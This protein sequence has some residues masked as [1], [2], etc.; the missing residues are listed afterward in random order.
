M[1]AAAQA[2][3]AISLH[4]IATELNQRGIPAARGRAWWAVGVQRAMTEP[5]QN[6]I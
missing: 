3:G 5:G 2:A 6:S 4:L 1:I